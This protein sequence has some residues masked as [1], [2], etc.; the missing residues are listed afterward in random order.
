MKAS[1]LI[2]INGFHPKHNSMKMG[3]FNCQFQLGHG[4][5][6]SV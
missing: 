4:F 1:F 3:K 5:L 6:K 2:E